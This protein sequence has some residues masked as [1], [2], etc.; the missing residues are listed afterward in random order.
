MEIVVTPPWLEILEALSAAKPYRAN[1]V[2]RV[3]D[4]LSFDQTS[5]IDFQICSLGTPARGVC[6]A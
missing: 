4:A 3:D 6:I 2:D 1:G 5:I